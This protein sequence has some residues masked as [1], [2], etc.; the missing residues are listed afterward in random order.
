MSI[1][2]YPVGTE[3]SSS[4]SINASFAVTTSAGGFPVTASLAEFA[5]NNP[6]PTGS[7]FVIVNAIIVQ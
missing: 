3:T 2:F 1:S 4:R 7:A 5:V 6:G